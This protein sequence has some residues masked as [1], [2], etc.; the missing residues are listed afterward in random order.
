MKNKGVGFEEYLAGGFLANAPLLFFVYA[1]KSLPLEYV[2]SVGLE[3][4]SMLAIALGGISASYLVVR[5]ADH[6]HSWVG[7][8]TGLVAFVV[9]F[10]ITSIVF[11]GTTILYGLWVLMV[12]CVSS[13][14][15]GSLRRFLVRK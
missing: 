11:G 9:N 6:D 4:G 8:R 7:L 2:W 5:R 10:A 3:L 13:V 15:G 12:F 1:V 14:T